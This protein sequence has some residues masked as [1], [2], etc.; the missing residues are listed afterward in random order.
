MG[1]AASSFNSRHEVVVSGIVGGSA[2]DGV[3]VAASASV[4]TKGT[5][6]TNSAYKPSFTWNML[7]LCV[8]NASAE[9]YLMDIGVDDGSSNV[10]VIAPDLRVPGLRIARSGAMHFQ[11]PLHVPQGK[12]L[13]FRCQSASGTNGV[14]I[15]C[16]GSSNGIYGAQGYS[17][18]VSLYTPAA[19]SRGIT[20][21]P[22]GT[23]N[24]KGSW[25]QMTSS[26]SDRVVGLMMAVGDAGDIARAAAQNIAIDIGIGASSSERVV[27]PDITFTADTNSDQWGPRVT[28]IYPCDI[29]SGTR[30]ALRSQCSVNTASDRLIDCTLHGFVP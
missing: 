28:G 7:N 25:V 12:Q 1:R 16:G 5:W 20:I 2:T 17:R 9:S 4:D 11:L 3:T 10:F 6:V 15:I 27:V 18:M 14:R 8:W 23:A 22:G 13:A 30:F 19:G 24:T 21:D 29:P 26:S